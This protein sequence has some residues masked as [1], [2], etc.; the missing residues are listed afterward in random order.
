MMQA[1]HVA[2][3]PITAV[4]ACAPAGP[5]WSV[6]YGWQ[7]SEEGPTHLAIASRAQAKYR[8]RVALP[9]TCQPRVAGPFPQS[10][11]G[12]FPNRHRMTACH[13]VTA[14]K[15]LAPCATGRCR[16]LILLSR[17]T[18]CFVLSKHCETARHP[19]RRSSHSGSGLWSFR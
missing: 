15:G 7:G 1:P 19:C 3:Q 4:S 17:T 5:I 10:L 14:R 12:L 2:A 6:P 11:P 16:I 8:R 18:T 13:P 9:E